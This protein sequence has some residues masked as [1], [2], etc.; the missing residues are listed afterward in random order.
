MPLSEVTGRRS[1]LESGA[2]PFQE[3]TTSV[4]GEALWLSVLT[5]TL[6]HFP[7]RTS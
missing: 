4:E 2:R 3:K 1:N 5:P 6:H 7:L